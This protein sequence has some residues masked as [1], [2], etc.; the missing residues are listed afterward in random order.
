[1]NRHNDD[2][3]FLTLVQGQAIWINENNT[4]LDKP[5]VALVFFG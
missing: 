1:M 5:S 4:T 2:R 3:W